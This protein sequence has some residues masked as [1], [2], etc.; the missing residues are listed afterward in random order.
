MTYDL[1]HHHHRLQ[2]LTLSSKFQDSTHHAGKSPIDKIMV[3]IGKSSAC[4]IEYTDGVIDQQEQESTFFASQVLDKVE[5]HFDV[6]GK[7]RIYFRPLYSQ[8]LSSSLETMLKE[9]GWSLRGLYPWSYY[10]GNYIAFLSNRKAIREYVRTQRKEGAFFFGRL[11][12]IAY[13]K[14][15]VPPGEKYPVKRSESKHVLSSEDFISR[16]SRRERLKNFAVS[17]GLNIKIVESSAEGRETIQS[18][19][20]ASFLLQPHG[21]SVRHNIYEGMLLGIPSIIEKTSYNTELFDNFTQW[22]FDEGEPPINLGRCN[23]EGDKLIDVFE[24]HM[25]PDA[26]V[27]SIL[28]EME[29]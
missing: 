6:S 10:A 14:V 28:K 4:V 3:L 5:T 25:T 9:R 17:H 11:H 16:P 26:I 29:T 8:T 2:Y 12:D 15:D 21:I 20:N 23:L 24:M 18:I 1:Y 13:P 22:N 7:K 19:M 27:A